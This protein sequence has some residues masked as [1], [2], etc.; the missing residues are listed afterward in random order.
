MNIQF[1]ENPGAIHDFVQ[2][3][4]CKSEKRE[5]WIGT[6]VMDRQLIADGA[7]IDKILLNFRDM[8]QKMLLFGHIKGKEGSFVGSLFLNYLSSGTIPWTID[9]FIDYVTDSKMLRIEAQKFYFGVD[10]NSNILRLL[11]TNQE[12]DLYI[13]NLLYDFFI[14]TDEFIEECKKDMLKLAEEVKAFRNQM[15]PR[16]LENQEKFD[17]NTFT[18][19]KSPFMKNSNW[20]KGIDDIIISFALVHKY[21]GICTKIKT[22]GIFLFGFDYMKTLHESYDMDIKL[23]SFGNAIGDE[24]RIRILN[25]LAQNGECTLA[26]LSRQLGVVN[27]VIMYHLDIL[28]KESLL[29]YRSQGRKVLYCIN[30]KQFDKAVKIINSIYGGI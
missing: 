30:R 27:T 19:D 17:Y 16:I 9:G 12:L 29:L 11:R 28:K 1:R 5:K 14:F 13:K 26:D 2:I 4:I 3:I 10:E 15:A 20:C 21:I 7:V 24:M 22:T 23:S 8:N 18:T 6:Y 25:A